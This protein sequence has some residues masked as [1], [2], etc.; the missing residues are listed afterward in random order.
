MPSFDNVGKHKD[1]ETIWVV[2]Y[3][4]YFLQKYDTHINVEI[5]TSIKSFKYIYKYVYKGTDRAEVQLR[6]IAEENEDEVQYLDADELRTYI[7]SMYS[8]HMKQPGGSWASQQTP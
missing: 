8:Q 6:T 7:D 3:N 5:S 4:A 1:G 2:P